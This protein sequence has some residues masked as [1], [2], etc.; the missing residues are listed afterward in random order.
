MTWDINDLWIFNSEK[1]LKYVFKL[2]GI[3]GKDANMNCCVYLGKYQ[4][5]V[6]G[7]YG[8]TMKVWKIDQDG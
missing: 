7:Y 4:Y 2:K 3:G 6:A 1:H 5:L 8:G